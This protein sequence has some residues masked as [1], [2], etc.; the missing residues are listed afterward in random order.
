MQK[1]NLPKFFEQEITNKARLPKSERSEKDLKK[2]Q[3]K[4][5]KSKPKTKKV[6]KEKDADT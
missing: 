5:K 6:V 3:Q 2:E 1:Q 4:V